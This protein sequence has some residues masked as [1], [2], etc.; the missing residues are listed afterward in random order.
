M[1]EKTGINWAEPGL[2]MRFWSKVPVAGPDDCWPWL[3]AV[4]AN[5]YG[6][7]FIGQGRGTTTAHRVS[8]A[9]GHGEP[10]G[11]QV[12]HLC[13]NRDCVNSTHL[14]AVTNRENALRGNH[15]RLVT[16]CRHG[17]PYTPENTGLNARG[18]R[19]CRMCSRARDRRRRPA[20]WWRERRKRL[21]GV[22]HGL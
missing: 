4:Q 5:G 13:R 14:E 17:H 3:G 22:N 1:S 18:R 20:S 19:F 11:L 10:V 6:I 7:F 9:I 21:A 15:G 8:Y 2:L 12:D 16:V